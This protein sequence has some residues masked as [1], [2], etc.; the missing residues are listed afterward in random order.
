M[1][2]K[3]VNENLRDDADP[4]LAA[5]SRNYNYSMP[6]AQW[7]LSHALLPGDPDVAKL[8]NLVTVNWRTE[9]HGG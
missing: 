2:P 3:E 9:D 4:L 5:P 8:G 6:S 7:T 1:Q